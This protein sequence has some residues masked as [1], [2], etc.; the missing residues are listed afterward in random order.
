MSQEKPEDTRRLNGGGQDRKL[1]PERS[2]PNVPKA[3]AMALAPKTPLVLRAP[4]VSDSGR[5]V[6]LKRECD[7]LRREVTNLGEKLAHSKTSNVI[8][9]VV[10]AFVVCV[11]MLFFVWRQGANVEERLAAQRKTNAAYQGAIEQMVMDENEYRDV[12]T[13]QVQ[14]LQLALEH[15]AANAEKDRKTIVGLR[16]K[17]EES[18]KH[19][20][21]VVEDPPE[22]K[23]GKTADVPVLPPKPS[24]LVELRQYDGERITAY[25]FPAEGGHTITVD[26][27]PYAYGDRVPVELRVSREHF[28]ILFYGNGVFDVRA[29]ENAHRNR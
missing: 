7:F 3:A 1:D 6:W 23:A 28:K 16:A 21:V 14:E 12:A 20:D 10:S 17:L 29:L 26:H 5:L 22:Q 25:T 27:L 19:A 2:E 18:S 8:S 13:G 15:L 24:T 9:T 11:A 4:K